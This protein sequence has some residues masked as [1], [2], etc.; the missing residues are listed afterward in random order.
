LV[1][2]QAPRGIQ[3]GNRDEWEDAVPWRRALAAFAGS[4]LVLG[5]A[6]AAEPLTIRS[7]WVVMTSGY[8]PI[9]LDVKGI[10]KHLGTARCPGRSIRR[11]ARTRARCSRLE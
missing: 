1:R 2:P 3:A 11:S 6:Q 8:T 4:M 10:L 5:S 9:I 7:G